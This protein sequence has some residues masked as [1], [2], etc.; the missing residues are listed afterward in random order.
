MMLMDF[1]IK[2]NW[3][4]ILNLVPYSLFGKILNLNL[5]LL[6]T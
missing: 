1:Q 5:N 4:F 6:I 3:K 2:N